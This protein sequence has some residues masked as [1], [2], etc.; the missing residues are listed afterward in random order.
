MGVLA[1]EQYLGSQPRRRSVSINAA[2]SRLL[3]SVRYPS[4]GVTQFWNQQPHAAVQ[5]AD[6][7]HDVLG[8]IFNVQRGYNQSGY[9]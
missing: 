8:A 6:R 9:S 4:D 5:A 1:D 7:N 2:T 3:P